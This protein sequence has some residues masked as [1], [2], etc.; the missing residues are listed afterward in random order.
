[1]YKIII[2]AGHITKKMAYFAFILKKLKSPPKMRHF[3]LGFPMMPETLN[4]I[5]NNKNKKN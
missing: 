2:N 3:P 5:K 4:L 1:L